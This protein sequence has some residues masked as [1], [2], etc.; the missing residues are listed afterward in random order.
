VA[1]T[2]F[3]EELDIADYYVEYPK[4]IVCDSTNYFNP[5]I[6]KLDTDDI[7]D[8][9]IGFEHKGRKYPGVT[10]LIE[11]LK[12]AKENDIWNISRENYLSNGLVNLRG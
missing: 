4:F 11:D 5:L 1:C 2:K 7:Q 8:A 10:S 6:Y 9:L 3:K 12:W